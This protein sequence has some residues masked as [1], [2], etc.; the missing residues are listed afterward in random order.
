MR[1]DIH[2]A[3][4]R[5]TWLIIL[6]GG[7]VTFV[8][9]VYLLFNPGTGVAIPFAR[10]TLDIGWLLIFGLMWFVIGLMLLR[11]LRPVA[12]GAADSEISQQLEKKFAQFQT[13]QDARLADLDARAKTLGGQLERMDA[14]L[15]DLETQLNSA[16]AGLREKITRSSA[17]SEA[18]DLDNELG[19]LATAIQDAHTRLD[20]LGDVSSRLYDLASQLDTLY[21]TVQDAH[22]RID[23]IEQASHR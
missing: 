15:R 10:T 18:R 14:R 3:A 6:V 21:V 13:T 7:L 11:W 5:I 23:A 9:L 17:S 19:S 8:A 1:T 12:A 22:R 2:P 4:R 20:D 16:Q